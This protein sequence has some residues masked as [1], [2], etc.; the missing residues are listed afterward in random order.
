[1]SGSLYAIDFDW[2][3]DDGPRLVGPFYSRRAATAWLVA[4][5]FDAEANVTSLWQ[6]TPEEKTGPRAA[7]IRQHQERGQ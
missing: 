3:S 5:P 6:P 4:Q 1:M 2:R 7:I